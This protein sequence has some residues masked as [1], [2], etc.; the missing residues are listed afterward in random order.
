MTAMTKAPLEKQ[1][2]PDLFERAMQGVK[3]LPGKPTLPTQTIPR[4][5]ALTPRNSKPAAAAVPDPSTIPPPPAI[6]SGMDK[7]QSERLRR[8]RLPIDGKIDLHG[9]KQL[10]A[11]ARLAGFIARAHDQGKRC[12]LVVTG[13]GSRTGGDDTDFFTNREPGVLRRNVPRWLMEPGM[14]EKVLSIT[15]AQPKH[16]GA[17]ALYV[18]LRRRR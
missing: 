12:L 10:E 1:E 15:E 9:L 4:P 11:H 16:G 6:G 17:G 14:R 18:L 2:P 7:R 8:G 5:A 13:K 3:P